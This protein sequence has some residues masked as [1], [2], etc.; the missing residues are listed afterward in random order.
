LSFDIPFIFFFGGAFSQY[1]SIGAEETH[2][3]AVQ[4][5]WCFF[6]NYIAVRNAITNRNTPERML[7]PIEISL[8]HTSTLPFGG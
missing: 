4:F 3:Q 1:A 2:H 7:A 5:A 8:R 6:K